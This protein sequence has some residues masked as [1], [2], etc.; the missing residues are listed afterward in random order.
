MNLKVLDGKTPGDEGQEKGDPTPSIGERSCRKLH[1]TDIMIG[2][3]RQERTHRGNVL[4]NIYLFFI[5][6]PPV[7]PVKVKRVISTAGA[8]VVITV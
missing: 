7:E 2:I 6:P 5:F 3:R 1:N 8:L 4:R